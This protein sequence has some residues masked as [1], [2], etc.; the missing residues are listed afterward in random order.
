MDT[1][2]DET[3]VAYLD[4]ELTVE[5]ASVVEQQIASDAQLQQRVNGLRQTWSLLEEL[6]EAK[7][8]PDL[9]RSTLELVTLQMEKDQNRWY[10][11][12]LRNKL[13]I[14]ALGCLTMG[15]V[16]AGL[17]RFVSGA[18]Q[19]TLEANL[20]YVA[21]YKSFS[22]IEDEEWLSK[23][24]EIENLTVAFPGDALGEEPVP[25]EGSAQ[26]QAWLES[27]DEIDLNLL[28]SNEQAYI[29]LD[30]EKRN[31]IRGLVDQVYESDDREEKLAVIRS[32]AKLL[33]NQTPRDASKIRDSS[34]PK[35]ERLKFIREIVNRRMWSLYPSVLMTDKERD[36]IREWAIFNYL[37]HYEAADFLDPNIVEDY[38]LDS[39][40]LSDRA[41]RILEGLSPDVKRFPLSQWVTAVTNPLQKSSVT[42]EALRDKLQELGSDVDH[43]RD[44]LRIELLPE[45]HARAELR[46]RLEDSESQ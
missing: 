46:K 32:Y 3:L 6:P 8:N 7:P 23:L 15:L 11:R 16:G 35:E 9:A 10:Q 26:R 13:F 17:G 37:D 18:W 42:P 12:L 33:A 43:S 1:M 25:Y 2:N 4:G 31:S 19:S 38:H 22:E 41:M 27:L 21:N 24:E 45:A 14:M 36:S 28:Q 5:E 39:L 29:G 34:R 30:A 40:Q 20:P 44:F